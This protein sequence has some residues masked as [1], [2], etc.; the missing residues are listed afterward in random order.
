MH[1]V[2]EAFESSRAAQKI[3]NRKLSRAGAQAR[4]ESDRTVI[5]CNPTPRTRT[6]RPEKYPYSRDNGKTVEITINIYVGIYGL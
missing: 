4:L 6:P 1:S 2:F 5:A 3:P